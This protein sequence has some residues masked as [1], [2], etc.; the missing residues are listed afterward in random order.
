MEWLG[1]VGGIISQL[2]FYGVI[3][4]IIVRVVR[5]RREGAP[6]D[7]AVS[8][9]RLFLYGL[10][11]A[12]LMLA[13]SGVVS[14][15]QELLGSSDRRDDDRLAFGLALAIVAGPAY[16]LLL[17]HA[18]HRLAERT[19]ERASFAWAAYLNLS[20]LVSLVVT[21]VSAQVLLTGL[22]GVEDL[23]GTSLVPVVVWA[24]VWAAHWFWLGGAY[25]LPGDAHLVAGSVTGLVTATIGVGGLV[26][27]V[28]DEIYAALV[29]V[30]PAGHVDPEPGRWLIA[31]MLG[32]LVWWWHWLARYLRAER[33]PFWHVYVVVIGALGGLV[34]AIGAAATIGYQWLVW[35]VGDPSAASASE[36][37]EHVPAVATAVLVV[38]VASWQYHRWALHTGDRIERGEP[39][40]TYDHVM[41]GAALVATV[42]AATLGLVALLEAVTPVPVGGDAGI[43]NRLILAAV[44]TA[45]GAPLWW[46]FWDRIRGHVATDPAAE[47]GSTVRRIYLIVLFGVGGIA[48]LVSLIGVLFV[49]IGDLLEGAFG[50]A[51]VRSAR[52]GLAVLATVT[53][54][55]WYHLTVFR[56]DRASLGALEPAPAPPAPRH[57][58]LVAP[59]GVELGD[60]L[61]AATGAELETWYR[62]D[63]T[64]VPELDL[65]DLAA[66]IAACDDHDV[67]VVVGPGGAMLTPIET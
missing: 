26:H 19:D 31:A 2:L 44:L 23:E 35:L 50:G 56:S 62:A 20:L 42:V 60:R 37:F 48:V 6:G 29:D 57:V 25:G 30:V 61:A 63:E 24:A 49:V 5:G 52:V 27:A 32:A 4:W 47:L 55:A 34:A 11:F 53:G 28:G 21:I 14:S 3:V 40:R 41:A 15:L 16:G 66:R 39:L 54:V 17:R 45:I 36:H 13:A 65:D 7:Q 38:G 64:Q 67:L 10:L 9:W 43:A 18:R 59:H 58:V 51:T 12:T 8:A 33:T 22:I 46:V 1:L